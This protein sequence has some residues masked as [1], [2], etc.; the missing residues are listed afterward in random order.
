LQQNSLVKNIKRNLVKKVFDL[1]TS[2]EKEKYDEFYNEFGQ[3]LKVGIH[4]DPENR[5][6][7]ADF[8][9]YKTTKSDGK[10]VSLKAYVD[11]MEKD[12]K[13]IYYI[14]GDNLSAI[15]NS[16]HLEKLKEKNY[17]VLLMSDPI[18]EWVVQSLTEHDGKKLKSAEKGDL[19]LDKVDEKKKDEYSALFNYIKINLQDKIKEVKPS[20]RLKKSVS[21]LSGDT[22]DMSAY[23]EKIIK[24]TGQQT[25][26]VKRVLEL[27]VDHSVIA[28][29]KTLFEKDAGNPV[30]KK[31][32]QLLLDMALISEGS[33][34]DNPAEF[35]QT[36][37]ELMS[38]AIQV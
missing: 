20:E 21:C 19:D 10:L 32:S 14:T 22:Y 18:D 11:N 6:K 15:L 37:G 36:I 23:M 26:K 5:S 13:E 35:S 16:P 12:Q 25:E 3:V 38:N 24:S 29:I 33:K 28:K 2:M 4:T 34:V 1:I 27:N 8:I 31:Y 17:E 30:L 9:R 7:I